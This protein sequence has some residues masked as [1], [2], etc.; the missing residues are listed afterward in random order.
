MLEDK[1]LQIRQLLVDCIGNFGMGHIGG[2]LSIADVLAVLYFDRM[3]VDPANTKKPGRDRLV[4]SKAHAG[5]VLY[6]ALALKG[7]FPQEMLKTLNGPETLLPS[8]CDMIRTPGVDMTAGSLG[9]GLSAAVG[10]ALGAR[11][12]GLDVNVYCI[13]GEG[14]CQEGSSWEAAM[15]AA[16]QK[17]SKLTAFVDVNGLQIDGTVDE[18]NSLGDLAAKW[19]AFGWNALVVEDGNDVGQICEALDKSKGSDKP[20]AVILHTVKGKGVSFMEGKVEF[21]HAII[22]EE[23]WRTAAAELKGGVASA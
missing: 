18:V 5:P 6:S 21:H 20:T 16:N 19:T 22:S 17:L 4:L 2:A 3:N 14:D 11:L 1:A 10:M 7:F 9:Q 12:D 8:H 15:Y 23:Q 13:L